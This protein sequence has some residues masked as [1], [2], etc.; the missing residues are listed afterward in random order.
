MS[1]YTVAVFH[2]KDQDI[3]EL[4]APFS[5]ELKVEPYIVYTKQEAIAKARERYEVCK[6]KTDEECYQFMA[7]GY[8]TDDEGNLLSTY[9]PDSK[10][11]WYQEGGRWSGMLRRKSDGAE[12]DEGRVGDLEF[13]LDEEEYKDALRFW[14]IVVDHKPHKPDEE[15]HTIYKEEYYKEYYGDRDTY[16]KHCAQ[17]STFA[18][19]T[20]DGVWHEKGEMGWF[21]CSSETPEEAKDWEEHYKERFLDTADPDWILTIVDCHI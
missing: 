18:V 1:H 9:N 16:A 13:G 19:L 7:D 5:E 15:Y 10:W 20:P 6:D 21:G 12:V 11:D 3:D 14:D 2:R 4:L 17:F 8:Q